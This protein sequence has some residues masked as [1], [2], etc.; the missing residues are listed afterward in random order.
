MRSAD[1][2]RAAIAQRLGISR[3]TVTRMMSKVC[4][5]LAIE[6]GGGALRMIQLRRCERMLEELWPNV[7][8]PRDEGKLS[9]F[10]VK[11]KAVDA[12]LKILRREADLMG[13]DASKNVTIDISTDLDASS[14]A[15]RIADNV[16]DFIALTEKLIKDSG[17]QSNLRLTTGEDGV[18]NVVDVD[19][20]DEDSVGDM[21]PFSIAEM[22]HNK[23]AP[24]SRCE[25]TSESTVGWR[26]F[27]ARQQ[28]RMNGHGG[29]N[30]H[31]PLL[32]IEER[33]P[34]RWV[35]GKYVP[36]VE[37]ESLASMDRP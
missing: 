37:A 15:D 14:V 4:R 9:A 33:P 8:A 23:G 12:V 19:L 30:G 21:H 10:E 2:T 7:L 16:E 6:A 20:V 22:A 27:L 26:E 18:G 29:S 11:L 5:D 34:G 31:A 1:M 17:G 3:S 24:I 13:L 36:E 25:P 28:S 32:A 35:A